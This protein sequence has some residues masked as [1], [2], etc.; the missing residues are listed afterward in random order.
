MYTQVYADETMKC[1]DDD[2]VTQHV[3]YILLR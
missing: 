2:V 3:H 1:D